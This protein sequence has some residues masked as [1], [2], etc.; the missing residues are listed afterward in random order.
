MANP[1]VSVVV[2]VYNA[3][4][5]IEKCIETV[6]GQTYTDWELILVDDCSSDQ[7]VNIIEKH[8]GDERIRL[9]RQPE[10]L[11]AAQARNR[12]IEEAK[13]RFIAFLDADDIWDERKL[14]LQLDF[15][16]KKDCAFSYTAYEFGDENARGTGKIVKVLPKINY[17]KALSRTIIF[18]STVMFDLD[19]LTKED[20]MMP[21]V[22]SED[23]A[24]WWKILKTGVEAYGM[25]DVL[26]VY[27]RPSKSLSSNKFTAIKRIWNLYRRVEKLNPVYSAYNFVFWAFR[28]TFRRL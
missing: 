9:I 26:T 21:D 24:T 2:P 27:R 19:K 10:N 16:K 28:A 25:D 14:E 15:M 22:P 4:A 23:T 20:I 17:R 13:G 3:A 1:C 11:K 12:G 8:L 7:S 5:Y 18:T 6:S